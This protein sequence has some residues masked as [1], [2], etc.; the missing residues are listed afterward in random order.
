MGERLHQ[1]K[2]SQGVSL[3]IVSANKGVIVA[4]CLLR[5]VVF[6]ILEE[7]LEAKG[8]IRE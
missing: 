8:G 3:C 4:I 1:Q 5:S 7:M 2:L 6:L